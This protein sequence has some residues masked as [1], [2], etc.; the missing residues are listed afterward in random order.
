M[1]PEPRGFCVDQH[2]WPGTDFILQ[3][4]LVPP[5]HT[6]THTHTHTRMLRWEGGTG[7]R[8][9]EDPEGSETAPSEDTMM[10]TC[11]NPRNAQGHA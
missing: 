5:P 11:P 6:H 1:G 10:G 7:S 4:V 2:C 8:S 3:V 9:T